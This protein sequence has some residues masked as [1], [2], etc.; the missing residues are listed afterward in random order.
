MRS[1]LVAFAAACVFVLCSPRQ[2]VALLGLGSAIPIKE[3][4]LAERWSTSPLS[5]RWSAIL[6]V[7][8]DQTSATNVQQVG[9]FTIRATAPAH[10]AGV[11]AIKVR[12]RI[13]V[14]G[15]RS[16]SS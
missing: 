11:V 13:I 3:R 5:T 12:I 9:L 7:E 6:G 10:A 4:P 2:A 15:R 16:T 14:L 8:F 1:R